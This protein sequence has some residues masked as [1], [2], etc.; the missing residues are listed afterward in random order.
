M[1][2]EKLLKRGAADTPG[3]IVGLDIGTEYIKALI[4]HVKGD[5]IEIVGV[6]RAHQELADMH[7][8]AIAD[9]AG[10]VRNCET[11]LAQAEEQAGD[12]LFIKECPS[13]EILKVKAALEKRRRGINSQVILYD[14][15]EENIKRY[16]QNVYEKILNH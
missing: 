8:G 1:V 5:H 9:I 7:Q 16:N 4:A 12:S 2:F 15:N 3:Y 13:E 11:A 14:L 6:G 10:V